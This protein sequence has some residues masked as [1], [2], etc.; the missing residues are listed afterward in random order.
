LVTYLFSHTPVQRIEAGT[1]LNN[2]AEQ[3]AL[4]K[5]G[6]VSHTG[7]RIAAAAVGRMLGEL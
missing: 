4:E 5:A 3:R 6:F 2:V 7:K 1:D